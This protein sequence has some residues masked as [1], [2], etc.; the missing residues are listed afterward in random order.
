MRIIYSQ[1][2]AGGSTIE[3]IRNLK[4]EGSLLTEVQII[5]I[6]LNTLQVSFCCQLYSYYVHL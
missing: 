3:L 5:Y 6:I 2:C 1:L 4:K